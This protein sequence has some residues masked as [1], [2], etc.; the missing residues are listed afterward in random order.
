MNEEQFRRVL[1]LFPRVRSASY[2]EQE[3]IGDSDLPSTTIDYLRP[4]HF[5]QSRDLLSVQ[6]K[7]GQEDIFWNRLRETV[8]KKLGPEDAAQF[9]EHFKQ[10]HEALVYAARNS[11][12]IQKASI[13][14]EQKNNYTDS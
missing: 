12:I 1:D 10:A 11:K 7:T 6:D 3:D 13:V 4:V 14:W 9:C 2:C 8:E 5:S